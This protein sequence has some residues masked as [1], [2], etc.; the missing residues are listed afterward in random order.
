MDTIKAFGWR[1][2]KYGIHHRLGSDGVVIPWKNTLCNRRQ[3]SKEQPRISATYFTFFLTQILQRFRTWISHIQWGLNCI[4][5]LANMESASVKIHTA[6][7]GVNCGT[8]SHWKQW[9]TYGP[10]LIHIL[11]RNTRILQT[12][13]NVKKT[14]CEH[15]LRIRQEAP[16][17]SLSIHGQGHPSSPSPESVGTAG[18]HQT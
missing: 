9:D 16:V 11:M 14:P 2:A 7:H 1:M 5:A 10:F 12:K 18:S 6:V 8:Y 3:K 13:I 17:T 15:S 4:L